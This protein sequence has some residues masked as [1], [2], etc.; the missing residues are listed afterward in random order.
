MIPSFMD[1]NT[2]NTKPIEEL[3]NHSTL[4]NINKNAVSWYTRD[5]RRPTN[6]LLN[7]E[8]YLFKEHLEFI[9]KKASNIQTLDSTEFVVAFFNVKENSKQ[10]LN[11]LKQPL[12][13]FSNLNGMPPQ[14]G[15]NIKHL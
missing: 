1:N 14:L 5:G 11:I 6:S 10:E 4:N 8:E 7:E 2:F 12:I 9:S 3:F 13:K 15:E